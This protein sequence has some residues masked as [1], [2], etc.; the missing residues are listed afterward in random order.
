MRER[1][2]LNTE[3]LSILR[4]KTLAIDASLLIRK[5]AK[6][7]PKKSLQ[8]GHYSLDTRIQQGLVSLIN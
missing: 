1:G 4:G 5:V 7:E 2:I 6:A 8:E 3:S